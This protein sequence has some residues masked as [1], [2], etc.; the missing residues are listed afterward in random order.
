VPA[1]EPSR[2]PS[3]GCQ[4]PDAAVPTA[5]AAVPTAD[6]AVPTADAGGGAVVLGVD[7]GRNVGLAWVDAQGG[8]LRAAVTDLGA[9]AHLD[10]PL[11]VVVAVG[12][13]TGTR[14]ARAAL[15]R[16]GRTVVVVDEFATSE[17]GRR[18]YWRDHPARGWRRWLPAGMRIPPRS[19]DDY[20]A[21]AIALR[22][23]AT[24]GGGGA[25]AGHDHHERGRR[26]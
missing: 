25:D 16:P 15:A 6:A 1:P 14:E 4:E 20:A 8:L 17:V 13:G 5:D 7:P 18:L 23:L 9:L 2:V 11:G 22:W 19:L 21:Y 26:T 3:S 10:V 24:V 12:D